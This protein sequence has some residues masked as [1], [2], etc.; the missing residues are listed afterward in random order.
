MATPA[1]IVHLERVGSTQDE[2]RTR[3]DGQPIL[4]TAC[5]QTAGRGRSGA[6]WQNATRAIAASLAFQP[7]WS[8]DAW[9]RITLVAGLA[10]VDV[11]PGA[12]LKWP[13]DVVLPAG[14]VG[15]ILTEVEELIV[16][17]G[18]GLNLHWPD[19]PSGMA[20]IHESDPGDVGPGLMEQWASGVLT[21]VNGPPE[22]WGRDQ[23]AAVCTTIDRDITWH[24]DGA[25]TARGISEDGALVVET[26]VGRV[27]LRSGAV[28]EI[29]G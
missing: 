29:R 13:N 15:G 9:P 16:V 10:A 7:E 19:A 14:K 28:R 26:S 6:D 25:G 23:Y 20:A 1:E 4:V 3:F 18:M 27:E 17:V 24:P 11:V 5:E 2:A 8:S 21:R 22:D 12:G